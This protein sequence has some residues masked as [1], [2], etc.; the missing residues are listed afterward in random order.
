[1]NSGFSVPIPPPGV[2]KPLTVQELVRKY[3]ERSGLVLV[4]SGRIND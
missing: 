4:N 1:M 3:E 2:T